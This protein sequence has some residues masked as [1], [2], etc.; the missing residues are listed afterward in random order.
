MSNVPEFEE[1]IYKTIE[2]GKK[3]LRLRDCDIAYVLFRNGLAYYQRDI[4]SKY[5]DDVQTD[6]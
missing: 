4:L 2:D 1:W 5:R 3:K 6:G